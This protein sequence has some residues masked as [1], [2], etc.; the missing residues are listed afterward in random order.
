MSWI[1]PYGEEDEVCENCGHW[2]C[3]EVKDEM[4]ELCAWSHDEYDDECFD[5]LSDMR[6]YPCSTF[7]PS[8][9]FI[10]SLQAHHA[11]AM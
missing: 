4:V 3:G 11:R 7:C 10:A 6:E 1:P 2:L 9:A 5:V 8:K